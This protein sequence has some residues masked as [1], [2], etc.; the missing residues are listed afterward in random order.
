MAMLAP[1][2]RVNL[3]QF[4]VDHFSLSEL[5]D[6]VFNMGIGSDVL[7]STTTPEMSRALIEYCERRGKVSCLLLEVQKA[8]PIA[9]FGHVLGRLGSC[10]PHKKLEIVVHGANMANLQEVLA[11]F[12]RKLGISPDDIALHAAAPGS[13]QLLISLPA[14]AADHLISSGVT[15]L[16]GG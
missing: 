14:D 13:L 15:T 10:A 3:K 4:L 12:A 6:L 8:R 1:D 2:D 9:Q 7:P 16:A 11:E 5:Q